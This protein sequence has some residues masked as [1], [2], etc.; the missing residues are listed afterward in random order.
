M[1]IPVVAWL[2]AVLVVVSAALAICGGG[3]GVDISG[4]VYPEDL[5]GGCEAEVTINEQTVVG[6][7]VP[8]RESD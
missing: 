1:N 8:L 7:T 4:A 5:A 3:S 6:Y 2:M